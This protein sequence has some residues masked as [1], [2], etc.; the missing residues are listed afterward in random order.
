[1]ATNWFELLL[2]GRIFHLASQGQQLKKTSQQNHLSLSTKTNHYVQSCFLY[3]SRLPFQCNSHD[4]AIT[5]HS[6]GIPLPGR[7]IV[8]Q[9]QSARSKT[10]VRSK[11]GFP[12]K[13]GGGPFN[14]SHSAICFSLPP[15]A[16]SLQT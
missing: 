3:L 4:S 14:V 7:G 5:F 8:G 16:I 10:T 13:S 15:H 12:I 11:W 9:N 2:R 1:M 6:G